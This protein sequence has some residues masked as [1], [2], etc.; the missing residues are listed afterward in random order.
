MDS[1]QCEIQKDAMCTFAVLTFAVEWHLQVR[2]L[3]TQ[4]QYVTDPNLSVVVPGN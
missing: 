4:T 3:F 2:L 1:Q